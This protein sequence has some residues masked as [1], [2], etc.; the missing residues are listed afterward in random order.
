MAT[1]EILL[2]ALA[3]TANAPN[4]RGE[5]IEISHLTIHETQSSVQSKAN[6]E[7]SQNAM[8]LITNEPN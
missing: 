6:S 1:S 4:Q 3:L 8:A 5:I 7:I 2:N